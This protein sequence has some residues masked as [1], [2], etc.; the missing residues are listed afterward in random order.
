MH[1]TRQRTASAI[2]RAAVGRGDLLP[3]TDPK[4]TADAVMAP[5]FYQRVARHMLPSRADADDG[6]RSGPGRARPAGAPSSH[7]V[8]D[9]LTFRPRHRWRLAGVARAERLTAGR[10]DRLAGAARCSRSSIAAGVP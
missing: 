2:V 5:L 3:D 4:A 1:R 6:R 7:L 8:A 9:R 10:F